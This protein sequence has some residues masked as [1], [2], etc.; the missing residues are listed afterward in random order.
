[1]SMLRLEFYETAELKGEWLASRLE[2]G[3]VVH[4]TP[5]GRRADFL[6]AELTALRP[7][8]LIT[9]DRGAVDADFGLH[10]GMAARAGVVVL[11]HDEAD[12]RAV[13]D[14]LLLELDRKEGLVIAPRTSGYFAER[15]LY[16][17]SVPKA[18]TH[19]LFE[20][21]HAFGY[22]RGEL[23]GERPNPGHWHC[24][25]Y[26]NTHT[27]AP[28]FFIDSVRRAPF[29]NRQHPFPRTPT[30]FMYRNPL[31]I[32]VSEANY[33]PRSG[34]AL[35]AGY[36]QGLDFQKRVRCLL[37]DPLLF[38]N[39]R[40]RMAAFAPWFH[41]PNVIPISFEEL[42]GES[43]GGSRHIQ[44]ASIWSLQLRLQ[45]PGDPFVFADQIINPNS[46]TFSEGKIGGYQR[47]LT[48]DLFAAFNEMPQDFMSEFGF[49]GCS[50]QSAVFP[51]QQAEIYRSRKLELAEIWFDEVPIRYE[52][53]Y[54]GYDL[55]RFHGRFYAVPCGHPIRRLSEMST[56]M[57][58]S[59]PV[60]NTLDALKAL[61]VR[62]NQNATGAKKPKMILENHC[63]YNL[64]LY[65]GKIF[66][67]H[68]KA[69]VVDIANTERREGFIRSGQLY[70]FSTVSEA[71]EILRIRN[72]FDRRLAAQSAEIEKLRKRI[73]ENDMYFSENDQDKKNAQNVGA[74]SATLWAKPK[75]LERNY[76]GHNLVGFEGNVYAIRI[77]YGP[78]DLSDPEQRKRVDDAG[79]LSVFA[80]EAAA[81]EQLKSRAG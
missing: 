4:F 11:L 43:G 31:D 5:Q 60:A 34:R 26:S 55:L 78:V 1:M 38:G 58:S 47:C 66:A 63:G 6:A 25:E 13:S 15:P 35:Y 65:Q 3:S 51:P 50:L 21:I 30:I 22:G 62:L 64:I 23:N 2:A 32:L 52:A 71:K 53:D 77:G 29:G 72:E 17:V 20:L 24:L 76:C 68:M 14:A 46:P 8:V 61:L 49:A 12:A 39:F 81:R 10:A 74:E 7:D 69:G 37:N 48:P 40:D 73:I 67:L 45:V 54:L 28:D 27:R 19:L 80:S 18:G 41:F 42:V 33:Y 56:D 57:I 36:F 79:F 44:I 59:L 70:E 75:L 16:V 9:I